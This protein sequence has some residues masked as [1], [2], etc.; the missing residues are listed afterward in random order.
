MLKY[1][2]EE[3][4]SGTSEKTLRADYDWN[5]PVRKSAIRAYTR[6]NGIIF[7]VT[8]VLAILSVIF[9][10]CMPGMFFFFPFSL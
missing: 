7:I 2:R 1:M 6:A 3:C 10:L 5:D 9:S 8:M 4:S